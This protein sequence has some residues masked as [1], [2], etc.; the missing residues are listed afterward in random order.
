MQTRRFMWAVGLGLCISCTVPASAM[1]AKAGWVTEDGAVKYIDGKGNY[2]KN[3]WRDS[4]G[5]R[6]YLDSNGEAAANTWIDNTYY[7][8]ESGAMVTN[9]WLHDSG[10]SGLKAEGWYFLGNDGQV[11]T[12]GWRTIEG[13]RYCFDKD[14][15]MRTGW[16]YEK[17]DIYYLG[18]ED[19]GFA[20]TGWLCLSY[21][22]KNRPGEGTYSEEYG[23]DHSN[24]AW[25]YFAPTGKAKRSAGGSYKAETIQD[26]KYYF[27]ENGVML[28][29][30]HAVREA[31]EPGDREGISRFIYLG[32]RDQ[33][34]VKKQWLELSEHPADSED[35][36]ILKASGA[37]AYKG[38]RK[39]QK[40]WYYLGSDGTPAFLN[41]TE[42]FIGRAAEKIGSEA[43]FFD[44]YGCLTT[45]LVRINAGVT[46]QTG[47]FGQDKDDAYMR[48][49]KVSGVEDKAGKQWDFCFGST[50]SA[51]GVGFTGEKD[52]FLYADGAMVKAAEGSDYQPFMVNNEIY[53]VNE[54]GKVQSED[55]AYEAG[56]KYAYRIQDGVLYLADEAGKKG[57]QVTSG[58]P[59]P[60]VVFQYEFTVN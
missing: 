54:A 7:V 30:W 45:G 51:K 47:Y 21:D 12:D 26:N 40:R 55:K 31:A 9:A 18:Q 27:D 1:A 37:G 16:H 46:G 10:E 2:V 4:E 50:G 60:K 24:A 44:T 38:P 41:S 33:G 20:R 39:G 53:L 8:D 5:K 49:G 43:Y 3:A 36:A 11:E 59:L 34:V 23:D 58:T 35:G 32:G 57:A 52:G 28:T 42:T 15:K 14:G 6:Y 56:G 13:A 29:G 19:E 22:E 25:F 17:G 48:T